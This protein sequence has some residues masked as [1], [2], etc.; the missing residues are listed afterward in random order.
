MFGLFS[1]ASFSI[2]RRLKEIAIKKVLGADTKKL[3][4]DLSKRYIIICIISFLIAIV[5]SYLIIQEWLANF[6]YR[7]DI[8]YSMFLLIFLFMFS[9]TLILVISKGY[10]ATRIN[11]LNYL[12]YE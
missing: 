2:E 11:P 7:I 12:K 3:I 6:T 9:L 5:P 1:L 10:I 8:E 4:I